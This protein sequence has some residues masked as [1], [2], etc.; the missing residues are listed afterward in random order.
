MPETT[1]V[2]TAPEFEMLTTGVPVVTRFDPVVSHNVPPAAL[3]VIL[4]VPNAIVRTPLLM[5]LNKPVVRTLLFKSNELPRKITVLEDPT[6]KS[7]AS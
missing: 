7:S 3:H 6:V 4:P 5:L 2:A 1:V